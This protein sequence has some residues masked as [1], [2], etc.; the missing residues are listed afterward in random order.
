MPDAEA[1]L[2]PGPVAQR[3]FHRMMWAFLFFFPVPL[4]QVEAL[5]PI[6]G[7][8]LLLS[9]LQTVRG[10][11]PLVGPLRLLGMFGLVM[12]A[13]RTPLAFGS[14]PVVQGVHDLIR[15]TVWAVFAL[16]VWKLCALVA[17]LAAQARA[18][19][20]AHSARWR[21]WAAMLPFFLVAISAN[22]PRPTGLLVFCL[23]ILVTTCVVCLLMGLMASVVRLG[24]LSRH[25]GTGAGE[26]PPQ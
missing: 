3:A 20:L 24:A 19:A 11:H 21:R 7:W 23:F 1:T 8:A 16:F 10:S 6:L 4:A 26:R 18:E 14:S 2:T 22:A 17:G 9:G 25:V 12:S 15:L 13:V 5:P